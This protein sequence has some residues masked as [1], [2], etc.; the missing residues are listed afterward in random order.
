[1]R[2]VK[3]IIIIIYHVHL[4]LRYYTRTMRELRGLRSMEWVSECSAGLK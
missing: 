4:D 3:S 1:M 2:S